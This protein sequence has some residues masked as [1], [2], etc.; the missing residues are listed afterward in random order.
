MSTTTLARP[1]INLNL[2]SNTNPCF[3]ELVIEKLVVISKKS[4]EFVTD[5]ESR[6]IASVL[7]SFECFQ[8][9]HPDL[10]DIV[11]RDIDI[12]LFEEGQHLCRHGETADSAF[13]I[14]SG[15][16]KVYKPFLTKHVDK[17]SSVA[18]M[19]SAKTEPAV[20]DTQANSGAI[21]DMGEKVTCQSPL[22]FQGVTFLLRAEHEEPVEIRFGFRLR[23]ETYHAKSTLRSSK[24]YLFFHKLKPN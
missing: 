18:S 23:K 14:L 16:V 20:D 12:E 7:N 11:T 13:L 21:M 10:R 19:L 4:A 3:N 15:K 22:R 6:L 17:R 5:E 2:F 9:L 24:C 1:K 8:S